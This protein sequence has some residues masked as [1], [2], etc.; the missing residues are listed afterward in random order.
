MSVNHLQ[1]TQNVKDETAHTQSSISEIVDQVRVSKLLKMQ[2][3]QATL[4]N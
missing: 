4:S 1:I 3:A 2:K